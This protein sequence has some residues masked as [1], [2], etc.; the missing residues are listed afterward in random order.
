MGTPKWMVYKGKS[1]KKD[2]LGVPQ[3]RETKMGFPGPP[4]QAPGS[5]AAQ[6]QFVG[7]PGVRISQD[8]GVFG[9]VGGATPGSHLGQ[10]GASMECLED[11]GNCGAETREII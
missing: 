3:L 8:Q 4:P 7:G 2:D 10:W 5:E 11:L 9:E 6:G 1:L